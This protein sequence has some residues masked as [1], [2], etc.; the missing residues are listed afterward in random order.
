MVRPENIRLYRC[1]AD[2]EPGIENVFSGRVTD[3]LDLA[4]L[5]RLSVET[6]AGLPMIV[7]LGKSRYR[8]L[9]TT[10]GDPV[11]LAFPAEAVHVLPE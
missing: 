11:V 9:R 4:A 8:E 10:V 2:V 3:I 5:V 1:R 6:D 7:S